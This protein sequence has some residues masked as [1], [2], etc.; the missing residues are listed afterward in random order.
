MQCLTKVNDSSYTHFHVDDNTKYKLS[1]TNSFTFWLKYLQEINENFPLPQTSKLCEKTKDNIPVT[2]LMCLEFNDYPNIDKD[3]YQTIV[4]ELHKIL[5]IYTYVNIDED[6]IF[7]TIVSKMIFEKNSKYRFVLRIQLPYFVIESQF[8]RDYL[9]DQ[10]CERFQ[11]K[12]ILRHLSSAPSNSISEWFSKK[13][14]T[15]GVPLFGNEGYHFELGSWILQE[16]YYEI[17]PS[18]IETDDGDPEAIDE[19]GYTSSDQEITSSPDEDDNIM[20]LIEC[21]NPSNHSDIVK[22][23]GS[24]F[25]IS[26]Q[27]EDYFL[28]VILSIYYHDRFIRVNTGQS[29]LSGRIDNYFDPFEE[30]ENACQFFLSNIPDSILNDP[31][32]GLEIGIALYRTIGEKGIELWKSRRLFHDSISREIDQVRGT[33]YPITIKTLAWYAREFSP[34]NYYEWFNNWLYQIYEELIDSPNLLDYTLA[35]YFYRYYWLE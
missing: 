17:Y 25:I 19:S 16:Q 12:N 5:E 23:S 20:S 6:S 2:L 13:I 3:F 35:K 7:N 31:I 28:P 30:P 11:R 10:L 14:Y 9:L 29:Y 24:E 4:R 34:Q 22:S 32:E 27:N 15:K 26:N 33:S 21:F 8:Q 1:S 18:T